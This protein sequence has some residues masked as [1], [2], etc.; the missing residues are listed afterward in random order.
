[1]GVARGLFE[2]RQLWRVGLGQ[3]FLCPFPRGFLCCGVRGGCKPCPWLATI[4]PALCR[5]TPKGSQGHACACLWASLVFVRG[6]VLS[7]F[8]CFSYLFSLV[9]LVFV[10]GFAFCLFVSWVSCLFVLCLVMGSPCVC[11]WVCLVF[12][13]GSASCLFAVMMM[14]AG[15]RAQQNF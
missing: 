6:F 4:F 1:M 11:S 14:G 13:R 9:C 5:A 7:L 2:L 3:V 10:R 15:A 12:V 8:V